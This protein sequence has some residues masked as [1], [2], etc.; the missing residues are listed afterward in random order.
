MSER[1]ADPTAPGRCFGSPT[2]GPT[3]P[4]RR[5]GASR[6]PMCTGCSPT[7][8]SAR[9]FLASLGGGVGPRLRDDGRAYAGQAR[10]PPRTAS[11]LRRNARRGAM[12]A[13]GGICAALGERG[14]RSAAARCSAAKTVAADRSPRSP[15]TAPGSRR[16]LGLINS[17]TLIRSCSPA[18][19]RG[20]HWTGDSARRYILSID[21]SG[22]CNSLMAD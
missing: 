12:T 6:A 1:R 3:A 20:K 9:A 22:N 14:A 5:T 11:R 18:T 21:R 8:A 13:P 10:R 2:G 15:R 19:V 16:R 4:C 17:S 7:T